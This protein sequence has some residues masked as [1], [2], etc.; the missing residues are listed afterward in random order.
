[1]AAKKDHDRDQPEAQ[2]TEMDEATVPVNVG[3]DKDAMARAETQNRQVGVD[4]SKA[5]REQLHEA[6]EDA[7]RKVD[8]KVEHPSGEAL[9]E[10]AKAAIAADD[11]AK[12][13][14]STRAAM[15]GTPSDDPLDDH[16]IH[17]VTINGRTYTWK[18]GE[19]GSVPKEAIEVYER[20]REANTP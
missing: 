18:D 17:Q 19:E 3:M 4:D 9:P 15:P 1:M 11:A 10:A 13:K 8:L 5:V 2:R 7:G 6:A 16:G 20:A 14:P 12:T